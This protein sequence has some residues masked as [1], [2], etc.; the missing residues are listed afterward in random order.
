MNRE[1]ICLKVVIDR[2]AGL[3]LLAAVLLG[4]AGLLSSQTLTMSATYPIPAGVYNQIVTTGDSGTVP[5]NTI[6]NRNSGNSILVPPSNAG[7]NVGIGTATPFAKLSVAGGIQ[8]GDDSVCAAAKA[9]TQRWHAGQVSVCDGVSWKTPVP[10]TPVRMFRCPGA[11]SLGGGA[12]GYYGCQGQ[13]TP[14]SSCYEIEYPTNR[15][16]PCAYA[17]TITLGP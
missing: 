13:L 12:W 7:G 16:F 8:L 15:T 17:G 14:I 10:G 5:A 3:V 9:G 2:K 6:L 11:V 4:G 1:R